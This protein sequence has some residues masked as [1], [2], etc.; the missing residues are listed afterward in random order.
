M[1]SKSFQVD[2]SSLYQY[3]DQMILVLQDPKTLVTDVASQN[4]V[5]KLEKV[6]IILIHSVNLSL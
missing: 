2:Q 3:I 6:T 5:L 1:H 4:A